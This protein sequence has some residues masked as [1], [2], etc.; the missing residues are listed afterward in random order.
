MWGRDQALKSA[1]LSKFR[2]GQV[3]MIDAFDLERPRTKE[4]VG[5]LEGVGCRASCLIVTDV[6]ARNVVLSARNLRRVK[7]TTAKDLNAHDV[8]FFRHMLITQA[9]FDALREIHGHD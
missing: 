9:G 2:D 3:A 1:L 5:V 7:V 4:L 6:P 8:L